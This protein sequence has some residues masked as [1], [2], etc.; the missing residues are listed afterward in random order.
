MTDLQKKLME[1]NEEMSPG[2]KKELYASLLAKEI[3]KKYSPDKIEAIL[4]NYISDPDDVEYLLEFRELQ[5]Y[6][7]SCK[8][9]IK[10]E[11]NISK[12]L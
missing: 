9:R 8:A 3:H 2:S 4:N 6:R 10:S 5:E 1:K 7:K 11:L 12:N